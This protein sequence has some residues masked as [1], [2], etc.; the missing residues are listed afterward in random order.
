METAMFVITLLGTIATVFSCVITIKAKNESKSI[1]KN[2]QDVNNG[3]QYSGSNS[4]N[5]NISNTGNNEGVMAGA[6]VGEVN[7]DKK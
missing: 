1:L 2:I 5:S 4:G 6:I 3:I 7:N